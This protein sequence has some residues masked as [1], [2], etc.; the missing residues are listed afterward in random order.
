MR[1]RQA[2]ASRRLLW[3]FASACSLG[4]AACLEGDLPSVVSQGSSDAAAQPTHPSETPFSDGQITLEA[5]DASQPPVSESGTIALTIGLPIDRSTGQVA[6]IGSLTIR[7]RSSEHAPRSVTLQ[8]SHLSWEI[9]L[10][11]E[12]IAAGGPYTL[13]VAATANADVA[14]VGSSAPFFVG[15]SQTVR[16]LESLI[17]SADAGLTSTLYPGSSP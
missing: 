4:L 12:S 15:A 1:S 7:L 16:V 17:C 14:C 8:L 10:S 5:A 13:E 6:N 3:L 11:L 9:N 2:A